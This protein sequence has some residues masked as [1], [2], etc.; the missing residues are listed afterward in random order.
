MKGAIASLILLV[1]CGVSTGA[2]AQD[3][4]AARA[5]FRAG[6]T[7]LER[8]EYDSAEE[9]F[10][11]SLST[12]PTA[13]AQC[14]LALTYDR[15]GDHGPQAL[16]AYEACADL[17]ESGQY[18]EHALDRA[19]ELRAERDAALGVT[20]TP[21]PI[22]APDSSVGGIPVTTTTGGETHDPDGPAYYTQA[23]PPPPRQSRALLALGIIGMA[24]GAAAIVVAA[25]L[26]TSA[27]DEADALPFYGLE[28]RDGVYLV[29]EGSAAADTLSSAQTKSDAATAMYVVGGV[30]GALGLTFLIVHFATSDDGGEAA[31]ALTPVE[32]G[33]GI[34]ARLA[35]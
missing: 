15:W 35:L 21:V 10:R 28:M 31:V 27:Q 30:L 17:D 20:A 1:A 3:R 6:T 7:S 29:P 11:R 22:G 19:E 25:L 26:A 8:G 9:L 34:T 33:A 4:D 5:D 12:Y 24:A 14:N 16:E 23:P 18:R 2:L 32:G 13:A